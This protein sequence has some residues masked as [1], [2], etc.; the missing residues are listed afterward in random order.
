VE[1]YVVAADVY[2]LSP[3]IGRGGWTWY[4]G[5]AGW[6]YRLIAE[7]LLGL[8]LEVDHLRFEPCLPAAW[9]SFKMHYRYRE[10]VYHIEIVQGADDAGI[11]IDGEE[12]EGDAI[13]LVDDRREHSVEVRLKKA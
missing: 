12:H 13:P 2:A 7:S 6:M 1:P 9:R 4:T 3:H 5:S 10:T 8:Q 11:T